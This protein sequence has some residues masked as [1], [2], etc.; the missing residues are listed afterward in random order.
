MPKRTTDELSD[1]KAFA[2]VAH[3]GG[4]R[5]AARLLQLSPSG[6]SDAVRRLENHLGVRLLHRT[7][8][9]VLPTE[10]GQQLLERVAPAFVELELALQIVNSARDKPAGNLRLNV[11]VNAARLFLAPLL[12][13][14]LQ[15]F[16]DISVEVIAETGVIDIVAAGCDAG[17][18]YDD[19]LEQDMIAMP[20]GPREQRFATAAAPALLEKTGRPQ[21]PDDLLKMPCIRGRFAKGNLERWSFQRGEEVCHIEP[22][23]P[24]IYSG[25]TGADLGVS[26]AREGVGVIHLFEGWLQPYLDI[27]ELEPILEPWWQ[28][29]AGP[30]LYY[31]G[32]K[33]LPP[34]LRAFI[35]F[36]KAG[37]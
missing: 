12:T 17:I 22:H 6:L 23:G 10:Q 25:G 37:E 29:F 35:D 5:E 14:F 31:S 13:R 15:R 24:L 26:L 36:V 19:R 32:R 18:R 7:T 30:F 3:A 1:L 2:A 34:P 11:P 33:L 21:H 27:G 16:P 9:S 28:P 4:F 8:R 20:I